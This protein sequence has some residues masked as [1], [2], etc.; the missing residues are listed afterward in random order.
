MDYKAMLR[1]ADAAYAKVRP[2]DVFWRVLTVAAFF[3][4][5]SLGCW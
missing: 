3:A 1:R 4:G 2:S 5:L